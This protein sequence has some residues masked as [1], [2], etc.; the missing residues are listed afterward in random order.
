[1]KKKLLLMITLL[2]LPAM[3]LSACSPTDRLRDLLS[4]ATDVLSSRQ[5]GEEGAEATAVPEAEVSSPS[6]AT[7]DSSR[8]VTTS[9]DVLTALQD[10]LGQIYEI[11]N[12][13]VVYIQVTL[14]SEMPNLGNFEWPEGF[15]VPE[16]FDS[17]AQASGFVWDEEGHIVTNNHVVE[18]AS[19]SEMFMMISPCRRCCHGDFRHQG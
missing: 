17:T 19:H 5:A 11:V 3:L 18:D 9:G 4:Q 13:S 14:R 10:T 16:Q 1:M 12:P 2:L 15:G 8:V 6:T 7:D